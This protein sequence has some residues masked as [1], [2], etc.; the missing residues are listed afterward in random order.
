M[1][2]RAA[3]AKK[4]FEPLVLIA[5][6]AVVPVVLIEARS[7]SLLWLEITYIANWLIWAVFVLEYA[8]LVTLVDD[9][10]AYTRSAWLDILI[11]IVSFPLLPAMLAATR[12]ARLARLTRV[13][14]ILRLVRVGAAISRA[15][16]ALR[17]MLGKRKL[18]YLITVTVILATAFGVLLVLVEPGVE[19]VEEGVWW[20][21]VTLTTVGYG[22]LYPATTE[23]RIVGALLMMLSIV[24]VATMTA[25]MAA[26]FVDDDRPDLTAELAELNDRLERIEM[27]LR[28]EEPPESIDSAADDE[29]EP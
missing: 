2:Q 14:R 3:R 10:W 25:V 11:I 18:G 29:T 15:G 23:G 21:I 19:T 1:N 16:Q 12:L 9:K 27:V 20:A 17:R 5:A 4:L 28:G 8:V 13:L 26:T 22:D 24:F 7:P 6:L